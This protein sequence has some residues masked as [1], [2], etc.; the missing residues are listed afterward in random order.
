MKPIDPKST[1]HEGPSSEAT[2]KKLRITKELVQV[3]ATKALAGV[4]GGV[5]CGTPSTITHPDDGNGDRP[6]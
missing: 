4:Q 6:C 1:I 3:L 2:P 5:V